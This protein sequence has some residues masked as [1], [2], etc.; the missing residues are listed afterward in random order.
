[1]GVERE[2]SILQV[3]ATKDDSVHLFFYESLH[4]HAINSGLCLQQKRPHIVELFH[5]RC[6]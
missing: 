2:A 3:W 6:L 4:V 1:M 5:L